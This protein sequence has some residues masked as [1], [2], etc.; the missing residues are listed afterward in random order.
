M[1]IIASSHTTFQIYNN[2]SVHCTDRNCWERLERYNTHMQVWSGCLMNFYVF[3]IPGWRW[4]VTGCI[5]SIFTALKTLYIKFHVWTNYTNHQYRNV[6]FLSV[7]I[8]N[9]TSK[10]RNKR[11]GRVI[12]S[13]SNWRRVWC[14]AS[15]AWD[16]CKNWTTRVFMFVLKI[17]VLLSIICIYYYYRNTILLQPFTS[18]MM[19]TTIIIII[20]QMWKE[21]IMVE[22]VDG[23]PTFEPYLF[24][25]LKQ[26]C[27][28][29]NFEG[30][31]T[32]FWE[33]AVEGLSRQC[34]FT[35]SGDW[36]PIMWS[37]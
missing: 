30:T 11:S 33:D 21:E 7:F 12:D 26:I 4:C 27:R 2:S 6:Y 18:I 31:H 5:I 14:A 32:S 37:S 17:Y 16:C 19:T 25:V 15:Y 29:R 23:P 28:R 10:A 20:K 13:T 34:I 8:F 3:I 22:Y 36:W 35:T 24:N 9:F 1:T